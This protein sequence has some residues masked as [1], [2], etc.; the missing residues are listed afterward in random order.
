M[1]WL[2]EFGGDKL[3]LGADVR[4]GKI[5]VA[6]WLE[7]TEHNIFD[8]ISSYKELGVKHVLC[9]DISRDGMLQ[10]S[11]IHLY[12]ELQQ[13][14]SA[15]NIIASGGVTT[16]EEI[17]ELEKAGVGGVIVGKAIYEGRIDP[18]QLLQFI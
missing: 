4:D 16:L 17:K 1:E 9:T 6:G 2:N 15:L 18:Q 7:T 13:Q 11:A 12:T 10:G 14:F 5:A 3:I 8:F